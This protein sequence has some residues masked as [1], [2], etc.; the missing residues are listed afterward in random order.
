VLLADLAATVD[1]LQGAATAAQTITLGTTDAWRDLDGIVNRH[2]NI[3]MSQVTLMA[4]FWPSASA[5]AQTN[6]SMD[7][8]A[9]DLVLANLDD[10]IWPDWR[11]PVPRTVRVGGP[12]DRLEPWPAESAEALVWMVRNGGALWLPTARDLEQLNASRHRPDV[13]RPG[14]TCRGPAQR[15]LPT[16][17]YRVKPAGETA[18]THHDP[19]QRQSRFE[20]LRR[21]A[22]SHPP[23]WRPPVPNAAPTPS[24]NSAPSAN[25]PTAN[26][27]VDW[28]A[29]RKP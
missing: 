11:N 2:N 27:R 25:C 9:N 12:P 8:F 18:R 17:R 28:A 23:T 22:A 3:R 29:I 13:P 1:R 6:H 7:P 10:R 19:A 14:L 16:R 21:A 5:A 4:K 15:R 24:N 26:W 20:G